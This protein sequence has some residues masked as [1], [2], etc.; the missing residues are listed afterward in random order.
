MLL[1][2]AAALADNEKRAQIMKTAIEQLRPLLF[3]E[4]DLRLNNAVLKDIQTI[5]EIRERIK[6]DTKCCET[7]RRFVDPDFVWADIPMNHI[8]FNHMRARIPGAR[9]PGQPGDGVDARVLDVDD[10]EL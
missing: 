4:N 5:D 3:S 9:M 8:P 2:A 10:D 7:R 1:L 6:V